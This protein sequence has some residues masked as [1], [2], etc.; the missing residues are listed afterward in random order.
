MRDDVAASESKVFWEAWGVKR[1]VSN[2][3]VGATAWLYWGVRTLVASRL[4]GED[5]E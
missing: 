1:P 4:A 2:A 5:F 3:S